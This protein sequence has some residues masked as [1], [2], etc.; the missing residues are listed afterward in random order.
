MDHLLKLVTV[1]MSL[2]SFVWVIFS[3]SLAYG[4][5]SRDNGI[6]GLPKTFYMFLDTSNVNA[7]VNGAGQITNSIFA[8]YELCFA[9][10][11]ATII[12][13]SV[14]GILMYYF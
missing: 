4:K 2:I 3:F 5:D 9:L 10:V 8:V 12:A 14:S 7:W 6:Y 1:T 11:A 13:C